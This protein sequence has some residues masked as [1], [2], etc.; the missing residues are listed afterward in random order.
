MNVQFKQLLDKTDKLG[1][2]P[3]F[4]FCYYNSTLL[5]YFTKEKC[6]PKHWDKDKGKFKR[7][8]PGYQEAQDYLDTLEEKVRKVYRE[9]MQQGVMPSKVQL[10]EAL[11]PTSPE[12]PSP[13][14]P[15]KKTLEEL[16]DAWLL[17]SQ[18]N[19]SK[20]EN[21]LKTYKTCK[22]HLL[23][24]AKKVLPKLD[25]EKYS[26]AEHDKLLEYLMYGLDHSPNTVFGVV[27]RLKVFFKYC[28]EVE[29]LTLHPETGEL[30]AVYLEVE[31]I[32]LTWE[33][34][35]K[36]AAAELPDHQA[37]VRDCYLFACYTGLRYSDMNKLTPKHISEVNG[38]KV[39]NFVMVK[40][41]K[42]PKK[43]AVAL[44]DLA[45]GILEKYQGQYK[46][47]LPMISN[48]KMNK[49]LKQIG[50][51]AGIT[52]PVE[53]TV[54]RHGQPSYQMAPKYELITVHTARHTFATQSLMKG[55]PLPVLQ[56][57]LGHKR[58]QETQIY[59][60]MVEDYQHKVM[61]DVWNKPG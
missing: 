40:S 18:K 4:L 28:R 36:L 1:E 16:F 21:T 44:N 51:R 6:L 59:A 48:Q 15:K 34:L 26:M 50:R 49:A 31:K 11:E 61:L 3:V 7:S 35:E 27:K 58:V 20:A 25:V 53:Q 32:F 38:V 42:K 33:E 60:K 56:K 19:K 46:R 9:Y 52:V 43:V 55:M 14:E 23:K 47:V 12:E 8:L 41:G 24:F 45:L 10:K 57:I 39:M 13:Q 37:K 17:Y 22:N 5:K 2:A 54:F 30:R 29:K